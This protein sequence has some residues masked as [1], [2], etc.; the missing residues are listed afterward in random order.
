MPRNGSGV[1]SKPAGTTA[2]P[3]VVIE[4][5]KYNAFCDDLVTDANAARPITAGGTGAVTA[6]AARTALFGVSTTTDNA[7]ARYDGVTGQLQNS[8]AT[9]GDNGSDLTL[10]YVDSGAT[11]GPVVQL[12]RTSASPAASDLL[13]AVTFRGNDSAAN[14]DAYA[15]IVA[16]IV[17]ATSTSEDGRLLLQ[18]AI[19]GTMTTVLSLN[20][21][22]STLLGSF[23][24]TASLAT[25][26]YSA[27]GASAGVLIVGDSGG[28]ASVRVSTTSTASQLHTYFSN[29]NGVVGSI[30]TS[31]TTTAYNTTSDEN[32]KTN[33][34]DF[35]SGPIIDGLEVYLYDWK[36]GGSG[37]GA[38]AQQAFEVFPDA[39]TPGN[40]LDPSADGFVP[41]SMDWS[42]LGPVMWREI[43]DLR[44]RLAEAGL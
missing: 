44:K 31:G 15:T 19:A 27:S 16:Q 41:W 34:R 5:A 43:Q 21:G 33:F 30:S 36:V 3:N 28:A 10:T 9:I 37:Y 17:D 4:S 26:S 42:K 23:S 22:T 25:A 1:Y 20:A 32:L 18:T 39:V 40:D 13:G 6:A 38:K 12:D 14:V 29:P 7:I 8:A 35:D 24:A 11:G 2:S